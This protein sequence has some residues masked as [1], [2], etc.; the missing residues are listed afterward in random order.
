M[1]CCLLVSVCILRVYAWIQEHTLVSILIRNEAENN[2]CINIYSLPPTS[3]FILCQQDVA[4]VPYVSSSFRR[5]EHIE[6]YKHI[7]IS[8]HTIIIDWKARI[9]NC[10]S[11]QTC[12]S[13]AL[14]L[15]FVLFQY[16]SRGQRST[17]ITN[18]R[19]RIKRNARVRIAEILSVYASRIILA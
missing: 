5:T 7:Y 6:A 3:P 15:S 17:L 19:T 18:S 12:A 4:H 10:H 8:T 14:V 16:L 1:W 13:S 9:A 2:V 11:A